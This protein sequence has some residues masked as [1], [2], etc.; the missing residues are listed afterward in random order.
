M[1]IQDLQQ[2][3]AHLPQ[4]AALEKMIG[5]K[6]VNTIFLYGLLASSAPLF[7]SSLALKGSH[8][9]VFCLQDADEAG[10]FYHDMMQ[11]MGEGSVLFFPST[12]RRSIKYAQRDAA[13]E[14]LRTEVLSNLNADASRKHLY[15]VTYPEALAERVVARK[16][17]E[18]C[19]LRLAA[20]QNI[21][22]E[23]I[24]QQLGALG[25]KEVDYVYEP[26]QYALRGSIL[27]VFSF[28]H[29]LPFRIDFFGDEID[30][31]R[32]FQV[33]DQLSKE[34]CESVEIVPELMT[35][36]EKE[37]FL[38]FLPERAVLVVR[39]FDFIRQA[40]DNAYQEGFSDHAILEQM[41]TATEM[42]RDMLEKQLR[43]EQQLVS[44]SQFEAEAR[45]FLRID[46][47]PSPA[48]TTPPEATLRFNTSCQPL[49]HKD[50]DL[51][52]TTFANYQSK[53]YKLYLLADS[54][55]QIERLKDIFSEKQDS[56]HFQGVDHT[57]H[58][59]F[60]DHDLGVCLFTDHQIFDRFH[61]YNLKSDKARSGKV[62][63]T[64]K[65][66]QQFEIGDYV[67]HL[68]HGVGKFGGLV[69][70]PIQSVSGG[71][72]AES[73]FQ[74][75]IK[76]IYQ[77]GDAIYV[78]I[79][80][81]YKVSKYKSQ[82]GSQPPRVSTLGTG[83]WERLKERTKNHIKDIARDLI[84]LYASRRKQKG[85]AYSPDTYLQHELEASFLYEDTP[86]QL[87]AT[88]D[89]KADME[90]PK[91]MDRLV[92]G[93]VGFGK[94]EVAV[95]AAFKAAV[96][97]KQTAVLVP[98]TVLAYQHY[99]TFSNRMKDMPVRVDYLSRARTAKQ[100]KEILTDLE[101]GKI[102]II[103][104]THKLIG[105]TVKFHDLG[106]LI[107]D[108]EQKFGVSSKEKLRQLKHN[109]DT[110][111]MSA[112][113]IP[114]TLQFSLVG[115]RDL[116]VIQ[117]PPPNRYPIQTEIHTFSSE[118]ITDA[119]NFEMSRNGQVFFVNN[120]INE[121][122][123]LYEM[124]K[125]NIPDC[126]VA[127]GHGQMKPEELEQIVLDFSNYDYDVLLSTTIVENG[128][129]IPNANTI[130]I[131]GAQNFGLSDLHQMRGRVGRGNRKAFCY[132]LAPPL[133]LL[134]DDAR[135]RLQALENFS[136]LGSGINIAM[137]DLDIRGAGNLLGAEQSGF[138]SDLGYETYQ[139]ILTE[140]MTELR[141]EERTL[142]Q[143]LPDSEGRGENLYVADCTLES[144]LE[145]YFPD[146]YVPSDSERLLLYRELDNTRNDDELKAYRRRLEDRFGPLPKP[147]EELLHVVALRRLGKALG[148]EKIMLKQSRLFL[149]LVSNSNSPYYS[150]DCFGQLVDYAM[151]NVRRC[152]LREQ[153][154]KRS[155]VIEEVPTVEEAVNVLKAIQK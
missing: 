26:G 63:L 42:E 24:Q 64:L 21:S 35:E 85:F 30:S 147:A 41:E 52:V 45:R 137:Q 57:L 80:S 39:D 94:T 18:A 2:L 66:I 99:N 73:G 77:R 128:I 4:V 134:P 40:I 5:E 48:T 113:P 20:G 124:I 100:T 68:D 81:L 152:R 23:S 130:I 116:S 56:L 55:K 51:M 71:L 32:T 87:K 43:S 101:A 97:G 103:I 70:M 136:D 125:R 9:M 120:R 38:T 122:R 22:V 148:C 78:S 106:L 1:T 118:I 14:I 82:D 62:A 86:D 110:L 135:R 109:V 6:T 29:E 104:G 115:A 12:Y 93:D 79:H 50:F 33:E 105:K 53:G 17:L 36:T 129:D 67:V 47:H 88:L 127:I 145:M 89:V 10:Y 8:T 95:R 74:E 49:F 140:A 46:I 155:M 119:I 107:I 27:D 90:S 91:P 7:F 142:A 37:P 13:S 19:T 114:R 58:E 84:R 117:T 61:K 31:I 154:G 143:P 131:N 150:S 60:I 121:L 44:G 83:Q 76:I 11:V 25:F 139:K 108:E 141:N 72:P 111:T 123:G 16:N 144:D 96:D 92:C 149:Y 28:S 65:E 138:I 54:P 153:S 3:Y 133:S 98:T 59:G 34:R 75:M 69:R 146:L 132:L 15:I 126:R 151:T 112:T 102:D